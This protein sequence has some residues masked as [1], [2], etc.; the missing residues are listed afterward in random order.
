L[1]IKIF[2]DGISFR[3]RGFKMAR[4]I[5][6]KVISE[7]GKNSGDLNFIITDDISILELNRQFLK[8]NYFTDVIAFSYN[9]GDLIEGEIYISIET[10]KRNSINYNVS[11]TSELK[12]V[13]IHGVLHLCGYEDSTLQQQN[14][15]KKMEDYYLSLLEKDKI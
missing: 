9:K 12:R 3:L 8:H 10:V 13:M 4:K 11:L 5:I 14:S 1:S 2:Y 15:M 7:E 6:E